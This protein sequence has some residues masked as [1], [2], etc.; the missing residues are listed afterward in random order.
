MECPIQDDFEITTSIRSDQLL[1]D[2]PSSLLPR[3][4]KG[5]FY[6]FCLHQERMLTALSTFKWPKVA[7]DALS[8]L[9][10]EL[11]DHLKQRY[12]DPFY[13]AP[14]KVSLSGS[15]LVSNPLIMHLAS[16]NTVFLWEHGCF[17]YSNAWCDLEYAFPFEF[18]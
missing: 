1:V 18:G 9:H 14:L 13:G 10:K 17:Y 11:V 16:R 4:G 3:L 15:C 7:K 12:D 5:P 2:N 8:D 6:M